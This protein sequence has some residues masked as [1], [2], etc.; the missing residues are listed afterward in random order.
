MPLKRL[1]FANVRKRTLNPD[2]LMDLICDPALQMDL[3]GRVIH[4]GGGRHVVMLEGARGRI[5]DYKTYIWVG[6]HAMGR[7]D[8][9]TEYTPSARI[10]AD[11]IELD[12][13]P[14]R[15]GKKELP[16][17]YADANV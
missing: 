5:D 11:G 2:V 1:T 7:V 16:D 9:F 12:F 17:D 13:A 15:G 6:R 4:E 8:H 14:A 10:F 3:H